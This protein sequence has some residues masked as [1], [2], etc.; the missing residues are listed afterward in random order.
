MPKVSNSYLVKKAMSQYFLEMTEA[1]TL[2]LYRI[3]ISP[4][5]SPSLKIGGNMYF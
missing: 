1:V 4:K 2:H 3:E 5:N